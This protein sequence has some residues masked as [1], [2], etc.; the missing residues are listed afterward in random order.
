MIISRILGFEQTF[1]TLADATRLVLNRE[2]GEESRYICVSNTYQIVLGLECA[3][4]AKVLRQADYSVPDSAVLAWCGKL[5]GD[6]PM[7]LTPFRGYDFLLSILMESEQRGKAVGFY[8]CTELGIECL[9]AK[10]GTSFSSLQVN[11]AVSP[12]FRELSDE[13]LVDIARKIDNSNIDVL[14]VGIGCPKQEKFM[15]DILGKTSGI[16]MIGVGAAFDFFIGEVA[17]S[18]SIVHKLGLEWLY[19]LI[20]EPKRLFRRYAIYNS[21]FLIYFGVQVFKKIMKSSK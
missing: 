1:C 21:K 12:P 16:T 15:F 7:S 19:R 8:G 20:R 4:F 13:E 17:P 5:L 10:V 2:A 18:P 11:F 6:I 9:V 14:L 3:E